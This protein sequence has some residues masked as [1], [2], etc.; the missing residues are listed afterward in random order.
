M[1]DFFYKNLI[2]QHFL[3]TQNVDCR[4]NP[5]LSTLDKFTVSYTTV[6]E[7]IQNK[8]TEKLTKIMFYSTKRHLNQSSPTGDPWTANGFSSS[9]EKVIRTKKLKITCIFYILLKIKQK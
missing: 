8:P 2:F 3:E 7:L 5:F 6:S 1:Y 4:P 9:P